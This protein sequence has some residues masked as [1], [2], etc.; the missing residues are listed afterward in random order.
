MGSDPEDTVGN[1]LVSDRKSDT[2]RRTI[3]PQSDLFL[4]NSDS[5]A[6]RPRPGK[7]T[8]S[9]RP[10]SNRVSAATAN[11]PP[12]RVGFLLV[13]GFALMT[14]SCAMEP[15]RA[16][17]EL[18]GR[19]LYRWMHVSP[20]GR[21]VAASNGVAVVPDQGIEA[22]L[23]VDDLFVCAG[24]NP[25]LFDD[26]P[27]LAWLRAQSRRGTRVGGISGGPV[28]LGRAGLLDG[29]RCTMH[30]EYIPAFKERFPGHAV[31]GARYEIDGT[32]CTC[33]GGMTAFEMM[34]ALIGRRHGREL[35]S[36]ISEW[37]LHTRLGLGWEPQRMSLRDRYGVANGPLL[38]AL[39]HLEAA[40]EDAQSRQRLAE[41]AGVSVRQLERLFRSHLGCT[42]GQH[43]AMLR[44][45]RARRLLRQTSLSVLDVA[46]AS[47]FTSAAHFSRAYKGRYGHP[48]RIERKRGKV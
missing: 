15:F 43:T 13:P 47:G 39:A 24:G 27:T 35:V 45:E 7:D 26:A 22:P 19:E 38:G 33:A 25:T 20:N 30:W 28:I 3:L 16:A 31:T 48:P 10:A 6:R 32:C 23:D 41:V 14:Y 21:P 9:P 44:L 37:F 40:P 46:V 34:L 5:I 36:A 29:R 42:I 17:N 8:A 4:S 11:V 12:D 1:G 18:S 2:I